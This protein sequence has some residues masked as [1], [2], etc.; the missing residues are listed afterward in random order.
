MAKR[1]QAGAFAVFWTGRWPFGNT[2]FGVLP[3]QRICHYYFVV[4]S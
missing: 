3:G 2:P 1:A 4:S